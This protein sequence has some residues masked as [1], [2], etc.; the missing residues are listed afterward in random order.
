[1][2]V[3]CS[4]T[5]MRSL[6][7][8]LVVGVLF[9]AALCASTAPVFDRA[10]AAT[11]STVVAADGASSGFKSQ[12][13]PEKPTYIGPGA[14]ISGPTLISA[15]VPSATVTGWRLPGRPA[16]TSSP[17]LQAFRLSPHL[18]AIPLLI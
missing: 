14:A 2:A 6:A 10:V 13:A 5:P 3:G 17:A 15:L 18:R 1:M 11:S 7:R 9:C 12:P 4:M 16:A 8:W